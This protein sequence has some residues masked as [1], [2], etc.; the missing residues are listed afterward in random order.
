[1]LTQSLTPPRAENLA[2][3]SWHAVEAATKKAR[4]AELEQPVEE[5]ASPRQQLLAESLT[6]PLLYD[7]PI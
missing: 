7:R 3:E 1:M 6:G 2:A 4:M 5:A